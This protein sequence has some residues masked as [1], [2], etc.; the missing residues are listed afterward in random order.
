MYK[1]LLVQ[2]IETSKED[3]PAVVHPEHGPKQH[4]KFRR[5]L[6]EELALPSEPKLLNAKA[7]QPISPPKSFVADE[8]KVK[9]NSKQGSKPATHKIYPLNQDTPE[10]RF[11][12]STT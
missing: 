10:P 9:L 1:S 8:E 5:R 6:S 2:K 4:I 11:S 3:L 12:I 7:S